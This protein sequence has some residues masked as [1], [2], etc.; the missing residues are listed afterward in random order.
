MEVLQRR[1]HAPDCVITEDVEG[2]HR[3]TVGSV[4]VGWIVVDG[5]RCRAL[6][7]MKLECA[8]PVGESRTVEEAAR[9]LAD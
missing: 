2:Q 7:G 9:L 4:T 1:Q 3:V 5:D 6:Y 8:I